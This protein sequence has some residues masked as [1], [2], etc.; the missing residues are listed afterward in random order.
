MA[1]EA[2][3]AAPSA[4]RLHTSTQSR[5]KRRKQTKRKQAAEIEEDDEEDETSARIAQRQRVCLT[6]RHVL[7]FV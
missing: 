2:V 7:W 4:K 1:A 6:F 3:E 5:V